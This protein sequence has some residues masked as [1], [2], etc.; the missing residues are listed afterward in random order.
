[1]SPLRRCSRSACAN[2]AVATLTYVYAESTAVLGPLAT[3]AEPHCYDLC[4][5]HSERLT[6]PGG[7]E[8]VRLAIVPGEVVPSSDDL[9]ALAH[10]VREA[11]WAPEPED[12]GSNRRAR[13]RLLRDPT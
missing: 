1:V 4:A 3:H 8:I 6:A 9:E 7:W 12:D 2:G 10:G 5:D 13:L 11:G